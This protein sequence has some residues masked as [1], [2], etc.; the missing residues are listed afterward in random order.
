MNHLHAVFQLAI[1][2]KLLVSPQ[3]ETCQI[4]GDARHLE[5]H[6]LQRRIAPRLVV[7]RIDAEVV[8]Q[9]DI[10]VG[11]VQDAVLTIKIARQE[12]NLHV[13][14]LAVVHIVVFQHAQHIVVIHIVQPVS[15]HGHF[16]GRIVRLVFAKTLLQIL[17]RLAY[18][19]RHFEEGN[20]LLLQV[21]IA[22]QTVHSLDKHIDS[23]VAELV[24]A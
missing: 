7:G 17:A 9:H 21:T 5:S 20:H 12:D 10:V 6:S 16:Q 11:H 24:A 23:L 14:V 3:A 4:G 13:L 15:N 1:A 18:P 22:Q 8:A 19:T 2:T